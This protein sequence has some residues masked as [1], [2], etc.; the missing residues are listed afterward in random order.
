MEAAL[1]MYVYAAG[2]I[3]GAAAATWFL[4]RRKKSSFYTCRHVKWWIDKHIDQKLMSSSK[5]RMFDKV[6][7]QY[8]IMTSPVHELDMHI[9]KLMK[10]TKTTQLDAEFLQRLTYAFVAKQFVGRPLLAFGII[11]NEY[12][13]TRPVVKTIIPDP[14]SVEYESEDVISK[15]DTNIN[16]PLYIPPFYYF[17]KVTERLSYFI[18]LMNRN[19]VRLFGPAV[20]IA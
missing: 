20:T 12:L 6:Y 14:D 13:P 16:D 19:A 2:I 3:A 9:D 8:A 17:C 10:R 11:R 7:G 15:L 18:L 1:S 5:V 4:A